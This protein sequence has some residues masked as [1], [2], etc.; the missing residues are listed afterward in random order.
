MNDSNLIFVVNV[1]LM[2]GIACAV[3]FAIYLRRMNRQLHAELLELRR[4]DAEQ[5]LIDASCKPCADR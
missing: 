3:V 4:Q 5:G 2:V 1:I